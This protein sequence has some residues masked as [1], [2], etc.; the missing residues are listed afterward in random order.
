M[1]LQIK[2]L[3][4][5]ISCIEVAQREHRFTSLTL[6]LVAR[7]KLIL[8][9]ILFENILSYIAFMS[10][11]P[12]Y[13]WKIRLRVH[14]D[15]QCL[16]IGVLDHG[17]MPD[18]KPV[19]LN[20]TFSMLI[21]FSLTSMPAAGIKEFPDVLKCIEMFWALEIVKI[22]VA[23]I[24][25]IDEKDRSS[26]DQLINVLSVATDDPVTQNPKVQSMSELV[27]S[28]LMPVN[29]IK[30]IYIR[31]KL[32]GELMR[33]CCQRL[34]PPFLKKCA[35][36]YYARFGIRSSPPPE[37]KD[38]ALCDIDNLCQ[39]LDL[40][41]L[42]EMCQKMMTD[43]FLSRLVSGWCIHYSTTL[44]PE[45]IPQTIILPSPRPVQLMTLPHLFASFF[46][47]AENGKCKKCNTRP[48]QV[49]ICLFCGELLC[50]QELCCKEDNSGE[51]YLHSKR[52]GLGIG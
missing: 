38:A 24:K 16:M 34:C 17:S 13:E 9:Q 28:L 26:Q 29:S 10:Q 27:L 30:A 52:C 12:E 41:N 35:L 49:A 36:L 8:L 43:T 25:S 32:R 1:N 18:L 3:V 50:F 31:Q 19:L 45:N 15:L 22:F 20:D 7:Q 33:N 6:D 48:R 11:K 4:F 5:T 42:E 14:L 51:C 46:T 21:D 44:G 39:I 37:E 40:P 23:V 47:I 2:L